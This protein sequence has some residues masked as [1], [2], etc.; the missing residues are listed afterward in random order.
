M[1]GQTDRQ[2]VA[3]LIIDSVTADLSVV[4]GRVFLIPQSVGLKR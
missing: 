4:L 3:C 2:T 1:D